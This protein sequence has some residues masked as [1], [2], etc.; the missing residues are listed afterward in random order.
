M[1]ILQSLELDFDHDDIEKFLQFFRK[2]CDDFEPLIIKLED[3]NKYKTALKEL[4][5][6]VHNTAWAS[7]RLDLGEITDFCVFFEEMI[8]QA[9]RFEGPADEEFIDWLLLVGEQFENYC[10]SYEND[11]VVLATFNPN[12]VKMPNSLSK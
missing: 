8:A 1:G 6:L 11:N 12:L 5:I 10:L 4:E 7:R 2:L 3:K 9:D